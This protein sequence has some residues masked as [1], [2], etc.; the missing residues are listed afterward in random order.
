MFHLLSLISFSNAVFF[1]FF[2]IYS[3]TSNRKSQINLASFVECTLLAI[4]SFSY[5][6][7]YVSDTKEEAWI[8]L[9][10]GSIGWIGF[11]GTLVWFFLALT[12]HQ[13]NQNKYF[14]I[15]YCGIAP[16]LLLLLNFIFPQNS[17]AVDLTQ[18]GSGWGWTYVNHLSNPLYWLYIIYLLVGVV[19]SIRILS[20]WL[21]ESRSSHFRQLATAFL[22]VDGL[23]IMIGFV[24]DLIMPLITHYFPPMTN[25]FLVI[26]S[27]SYWMIITKLD[28]FK[29]TSLEASEYIMDTISDALMV[30]DQK[31]VIVHCNKAT[32]E[33]LKYDM[34]DIVG[35]ELS[36]FMKGEVYDKESIDKLV[37][38]KRLKYQERD[39][40]A[41]DGFLIHTSYS[42]AIAE[43]DMHGFMG[44]IISFHDITR[45]KN[46]EKKLF[47]LAHYDVLTELPNRRYF[48][49]MLKVFEEIFHQEKKD[50]AIHFIDLDG[51]KEINDTM[52]HDAGDAVLIEVGNRLQTCI[53][54][55]DFVARIGGDE[56]VIVQS[57]I[58]D[59]KDVIYKKEEVLKLFEQAIILDGTVAPIGASIGYSLFSM[60]EGISEMLTEADRHMYE[61][62][63]FRRD[64]TD[65]D[66]NMKERIPNGQKGDDDMNSIDAYISSFPTEVQEKLNLIRL[67]IKEEAPQAEEKFSYQ[68]PTFAYYGNL[69][70]FAA[71]SKHIGFYPAPSGIEVFKEELKEYKGA[72]GSVQ[73]PLSKPIPYELIRKIVRFRV[74]ENEK[75]HQSKA[76]GDQR[77]EK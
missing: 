29:M 17:A 22:F 49:D 56:F 18:S 20:T 52:G 67:A 46:L 77:G 8:W 37:A 41:K 47:Q 40:V 70:H 30:L 51:F 73:F 54:D 14:R 23:L 76:S 31:G 44:I 7:F 63:I 65:D 6:F 15:T 1:I 38:Q 58:A 25:I 64:N 60:T 2:A 61:E 21:K 53:E 59:E 13:F 69:V 36:Y 74:E 75:K 12:R 9:H 71:Y 26:F 10:I 33:L 68:M 48:V 34:K 24:S 19:A 50:F 32:S 28:L 27:F 42:A 43:D 5:T 72:K 62:K 35:K 11:M 55:S 3:F 57:D 4:W 16:I 39:L 45:Q 66:F